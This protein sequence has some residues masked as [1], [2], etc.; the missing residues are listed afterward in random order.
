MSRSKCSTCKQCG[1]VLA[2]GTFSAGSIFLQP[3]GQ[4]AMTLRDRLGNGDID[5]SNYYRALRVG[6]SIRLPPGE[7][8][9]YQSIVAQQVFERYVD[10]RIAQAGIASSDWAA[11]DELEEGIVQ[12][13]QGYK[14]LSAKKGG[15]KPAAKKG[16]RKSPA[17][18]GTAKKPAAK[19]KQGG[20]KSPA[21]KAK[22]G[23]KK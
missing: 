3:D 10:N 2:D 9:L 14:K 1:G 19:K 21:K 17:K 20:R 23:G 22:K 16:K 4:R 18:K 11:Q 6:D 5:A 15:R 7:Q 13:G 12:S 8:E